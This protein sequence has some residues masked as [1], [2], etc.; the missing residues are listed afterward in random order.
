MALFAESTA[1]NVIDIVSGRNATFG[2]FLVNPITRK[3]FQGRFGNIGLFTGEHKRT[4]GLFPNS[5]IIK[6][7]PGWPQWWDGQDFEDVDGNVEKVRKAIRAKVLVFPRGFDFPDEVVIPGIPQIVKASTGRKLNRFMAEHLRLAKTNKPLR[8]NRSWTKFYDPNSGKFRS[9]RRQR[10]AFLSLIKQG[11]LNIPKDKIFNMNTNRFLSVKGRTAIKLMKEEIMFDRIIVFAEHHQPR[12]EFPLTEN[13]LHLPAETTDLTKVGVFF[14]TLVDST[15]RQYFLIKLFYPGSERNWRSIK[16]FIVEKNQG[17]DDLISAFPEKILESQKAEGSDEDL[18]GSE[19]SIIRIV[20]ID[21]AADGGCYGQRTNANGKLIIIEGTPHKTWASKDN[22]CAF[23]VLNHVMPAI[24]NFPMIRNKIGLAKGEKIDFLKPEGKIL[25]VIYGCNIKVR[26]HLKEKIVFVDIG[27]EITAELTLMAGHYYLRMGGKNRQ[28]QCM[29]CGEKYFGEHKKCNS[30]SRTYFRNKLESKERSILTRKTYKTDVT[31]E[32]FRM[33]ELTPENEK[34]WRDKTEELDCEF[35]R[36]EMVRAEYIKMRREERKLGI[37]QTERQKEFWKE[38]LKVKAK[39]KIEMA[40]AQQK[41]FV[42]KYANPDESEMERMCKSTQHGDYPDYMK[43]VLIFDFECFYNEETNNHE[44]Y[45][46]GYWYKGELVCIFGEDSLSRFMTILGLI[47]ETGTRLVSFNGGGYDHYM[48]MHNLMKGEY[49]IQTQDERKDDKRDLKRILR[50]EKKMAL[51][52][53]EITELKEQINLRELPPPLEDESDDEEENPRKKTKKKTKK[54][55]SLKPLKKKLEKLIAGWK[56]L[57]HAKNA[58]DA[59]LPIPCESQL[60]CAIEE[61]VR[62]GIDDM[63]VKTVRNLLKKKYYLG[64]MKSLFLQILEECVNNPPEVI[65]LDITVG[66]KGVDLKIML[67]LEITEKKPE[68]R[69]TKLRIIQKGSKIMFMRFSVFKTLDIYLFLGPNSLAACGKDFKIDAA[70]SQFPHRFPKKWDDVFFKGKPL[71]ACFYPKKM[72]NEILAEYGSFE[73]YNKAKFLGKDPEHPRRMHFDFEQTCLE[74]LFD[75]IK[76]PL[77]LL[78]KFG[79]GVFDALGMDVMDFMTLPSNAYKK[80]ETTIPE[81]VEIHI[82]KTQDH[83]DHIGVYGGR[84]E[85]I[86]RYFRSK[87]M[88][89]EWD[90]ICPYDDLTDFLSDQDICGLYPAGMMGEYSIG[91]AVK[92][93]EEEIARINQSIAEFKGDTNTLHIPVGDYLMDV[94][95]RKDLIVSAIPQRDS[96]GNT[97]WDLIDR[98]NQPHNW[99]DMETAVRHGYK[100]TVK[101]GYKYPLNETAPEDDKMV[102]KE[103]VVMLFKLK[104]REDQL[105]AEGDSNYNESLR[106]T[107]KLFMNALYG[108]TIQKPITREVVFCTSGIELDHFMAEYNWLD[109]ECYGKESL[110]MIGEKMEFEFRVSKPVQ[111]GAAVLAYSRALMNDLMDA[112]DPSRLVGGSPRTLTTDEKLYLSFY[113]T[114][115]DSEIIHADHLEA[116]KK[117]KIQGIKRLGDL[118]DELETIID[119]VRHPGKIFEARFV[120][121]KTYALKYLSKT[122]LFPKGLIRFKFRAKGIPGVEL[123]VPLD[124][125]YLLGITDKKAFLKSDEGLTAQRTALLE[126]TKKQQAIF[127]IYGDLLAGGAKEFTFDMIKKISSFYSASVGNHPDLWSVS[128]Q[129]DATRTLR[130]SGP[131]QPGDKTKR[132]KDKRVFIDKERTLSVPPGW[133]EGDFLTKEINATGTPI[134]DKLTEWLA[135]DHDITEWSSSVE[136]EEE[137]LEEETER[138][139]IRIARAAMINRICRGGA[140]RN[141]FKVGM[142][143]KKWGDTR[144]AEIMNGWKIQEGLDEGYEDDIDKMASNAIAAEI[145]LENDIIDTSWVLKFLTNTKKDK[146]IRGPVYTSRA[147]K[148]EAQ[149][150]GIESLIIAVDEMNNEKQC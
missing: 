133:V 149:E 20:V 134:S 128:T 121:K 88:G 116:L 147:Q 89:V 106:K 100:L 94:F 58:R 82:P 102:F 104:Q 19:Y 93:A 84:T 8:W 126:Q 43:K 144:R 53:E 72:R 98:V 25:A 103:Y 142:D 47:K 71:D 92:V 23:V 50:E 87:Q 80:W 12:K 52:D 146:V 86:K 65:K 140:C 5:K 40:K 18:Q 76:V 14:K 9:E 122:E 78:L 49:W 143:E 85:V 83:H 132:A 135:I 54:K 124:E 15:K 1:V 7:Q 26:N 55:K 105:K 16:P 131:A 51:Y 45:A 41:A 79:E 81:G 57:K 127:D 97:T 35:N 119:G 77:G 30:R 48:I 27:A 120:L 74:Y 31:K 95:P 112:V 24:K 96:D 125:S 59:K 115:T 60:K 37:D 17:V 44:V 139:H 101:S 67:P 68:D 110:M 91:A 145:D 2:D 10:N 136:P 63:T 32:D 141:H 34:F 66:E 6:W 70:K 118:E 61:I 28:M 11:E 42:T 39:L 13:N 117:W 36:Q 123:D 75:D 4:I 3:P 113:Y 22:N 99:I 21:L 38:F 62:H 130:D 107:V 109:V 33:L 73:K 108:K 148:R 111:L 150:K 129:W 137:S 138:K 69:D 64:G 56:E 29:T 90:E 114:D 46:V